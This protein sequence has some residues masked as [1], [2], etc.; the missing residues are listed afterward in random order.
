MKVTLENIEE[1]LGMLK[2]YSVKEAEQKPRWSKAK[3]IAMY[4]R[5]MKIEPPIGFYENLE[6]AFEYTGVACRALKQL[7]SLVDIKYMTRQ[8]NRHV[9]F[10]RYEQAAEI[11]DNIENFKKVLNEK[12]EFDTQVRLAYGFE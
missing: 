9:R 2:E 5:K 3:Q 1:L 4:Y 6:L 11:R 8:M 10:E 7:R 12:K